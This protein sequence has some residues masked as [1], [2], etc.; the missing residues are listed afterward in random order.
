M[1][2]LFVIGGMLLAASA[3]WA[4][5]VQPAPTCTAD[6]NLQTILNTANFECQVGDKIFSNFSY[7]ASGT[8]PLGASQVTVEGV[9][10]AGTSGIS[11]DGPV[12]TDIGL[13]F[14]A[15]WTVSAGQTTDANIFFAVTVANGANMVI[16]DTGLAQLSTLTGTGLATV[17]EDACAP[18]FNQQNQL[19]TP[20]LQVAMTFDNGSNLIQ[21]VVDNAVAPTGSIYVGKDISVT[22]GTNGIVDLSR[23]TDTFSQSPTGAPEPATMGLAGAALVGLGFIRRRKQA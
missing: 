21:K 13:S 5:P 17:G 6:M 22:A 12:S 3:A 2:K 4:T 8:N 23:V 16:T 15:P 20:S 9:G 11:P 18:A 1:K 7:T 19:C 10:P 14:S